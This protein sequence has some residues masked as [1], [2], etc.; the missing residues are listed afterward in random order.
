MSIMQVK[1]EN[2]TKNFEIPPSAVCIR[3]RF[4]AITSKNN[5]KKETRLKSNLQNN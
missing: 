1:K 3:K 2:I 5:R 4:F